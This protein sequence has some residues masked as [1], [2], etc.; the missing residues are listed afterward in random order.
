LH[1]PSSRALPTKREHDISKTD[2]PILLQ[3]CTNL[4]LDK[5]MK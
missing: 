5:G 4:P 2:E 3:I 1:G